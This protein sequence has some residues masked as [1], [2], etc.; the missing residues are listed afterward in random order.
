MICCDI[1]QPL[2]AEFVSF[3]EIDVHYLIP[4]ISH[5]IPFCPQKWTDP[6]RFFSQQ[7]P[8]SLEWPVALVAL[9]VTLVRREREWAAAQ[10][11]AFRSSDRRTDF[12]RSISWWISWIDPRVIFNGTYLQKATDLY[13]SKHGV[14]KRRCSK[15][16][17]DSLDKKWH[18]DTV[19]QLRS[20]FAIR[21]MNQDY[22]MV[23]V[24]VDLVGKWIFISPQPHDISTG[25]VESTIFHFFE[26]AQNM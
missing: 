7:L 1:T 8:P 21:G 11:G 17:I 18:S 19:T 24:L 22:H 10:R 9:R 5:T 6:I 26:L 15:S 12:S 13:T 20:G 2:S 14:F 23:W 25:M 3:A 16:R 4:L